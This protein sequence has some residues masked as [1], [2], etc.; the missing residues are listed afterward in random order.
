MFDVMLIP[1]EALG[2]VLCLLV[3]IYVVYN[4]KALLKGDY[5]FI[6]YGFL[7]IVGSFF[8]TNLEEFFL[9]DPINIIEHA[10]SA[11]GALYVAVGCRRMLLGKADDKGQSS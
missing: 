9:E 8:L 1:S 6:V 7:C 2:F 11:A 10:L 5:E 3:L 4:K